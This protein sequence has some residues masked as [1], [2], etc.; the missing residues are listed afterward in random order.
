MGGGG[1]RLTMPRNGPETR[2]FHPGLVHFRPIWQLPNW[3][4]DFGSNAPSSFIYD[5]NG[6]RVWRQSMTQR[7]LSRYIWNSLIMNKNRATYK[8]LHTPE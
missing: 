6:C 1:G 5:L 7:S 4:P 2:I 3:L 8:Q